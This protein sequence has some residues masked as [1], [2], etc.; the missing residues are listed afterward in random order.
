MFGNLLVTYL[1]Y[2]DK[3]FERTIPNFAFV[4]LDQNKMVGT[5]LFIGNL[6]D[7]V[8]KDELEA[9]FNK[10]GKVVEFDILKD[11][12]FVVSFKFLLP[13]LLFKMLVK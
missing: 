3:D 6:P 9:M 7:T 4:I 11:Y 5:K 2:D 10:F 8:N 12:G 13:L 1:P